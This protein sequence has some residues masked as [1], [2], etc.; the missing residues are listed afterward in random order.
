M[1]RASAGSESVDGASDP[2]GYVQPVPAEGERRPGST[3]GVERKLT[4]VL[5]ADVANYGRLMEADEEATVRALGAYRQVIDGMIADHRGRVFGSA[6][7][8]VI[9]EFASV[10]EAVRCAARIQ[11]ELGRR[12]SEL[13]ED[14]RMQ[15]RIG[16]N[17]GDVVI[18]GD[19][20]L[21]DGINIAARL[22]ALANPGGICVSRKV[23]EEVR[24]KLDVGFEFLGDQPVKN[25]EQPI[26]VYR[27]LLE[28]K[29][30]GK[31]IRERRLRPRQWQLGAVAAATMIAAAVAGYSLWPGYKNDD[32][33][34]RK[35]RLALPDKPSIAVL[36]FDSLKGCESR[37]A[38]MSAAWFVEFR[39]RLP[40][41]LHV[42]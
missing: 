36:P 28:P 21:G 3:D 11:R 7:D 30:A 2:E 34:Q 1:A 29:A 14:R 40:W 13:P 23:F 17:L 16:V 8:N 4:V 35:D 24:N 42:D 41:L 20:L 10:V 33:C 22:E 18:E 25:T 39:Q 12:N 38:V 19:N 9:A 37:M 6:G 26:P 31:V 15:F 27:V 5:L 32:F